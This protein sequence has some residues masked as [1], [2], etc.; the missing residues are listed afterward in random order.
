MLR[1]YK[2]NSYLRADSLRIDI[3]ETVPTTLCTFMET[4][5]GVFI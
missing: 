3:L 5:I 1:L 2:E 4:L